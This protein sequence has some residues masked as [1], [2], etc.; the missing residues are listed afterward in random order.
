MTVV[1]PER[2]LAMGIVDAFEGRGLRVLGP[3]KA[4]AQLEASKAFAKE[5]M[6]AAG[7]DT[8]KSAVVRSEEEAEEYLRT[9]AFPVVI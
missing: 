6:C 1:G 8:A 5:V 4:A 7:V 3:T 2:P 9:S